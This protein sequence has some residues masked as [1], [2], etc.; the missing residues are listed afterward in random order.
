[1][2]KKPKYPLEQVAEIKQKRLEEAEKIF[3]QKKEALEKQQQ[4]LAQLEKA[5]DEVKDH[6]IAKL[7]QL[8]ATLDEG[9]TTDKIQQMKQYLK[10]VDE[11][12]KQEEIKVSEQKKVVQKAS[13]EVEAARQDFLHKQKDVEKLKIHKDIWKKTEFKLME[14]EEDAESDEIGNAL[15]VARKKKDKEENNG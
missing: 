11:K 7:T 9:S 3:K 1:M 6:K 12:L 8:R 4:K 2:K 15:F 14:K 13:E 10:L 5:R